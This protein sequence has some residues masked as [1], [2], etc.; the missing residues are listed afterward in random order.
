VCQ[1]SDALENWQAGRR[2]GTVA[3]DGDALERWALKMLVGFATS[4]N[5]RRVDGRQDAKTTPPEAYLQVIFC[6]APFAE[7]CGFY[8]SE[9][10]I[11][12]V[13][14]GFAV[15][16][17]TASKPAADTQTGVKVQLFGLTFIV[18]MR[19]PTDTRGLSYRPLGFR[20]SDNGERK[21]EIILSWKDTSSSSI[22]IPLKL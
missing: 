8:F 4:G 9:Q 7:G 5:L 6:E 15:N 20:L 21:G 10:P 12:D 14:H 17:L 13:D 1:L 11:Q 18:N 19:K 2:V 3:I 22:T 16:F